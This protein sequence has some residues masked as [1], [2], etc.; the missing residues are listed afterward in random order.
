[1]AYVMPTPK[2]HIEEIRKKKYSIGSEVSNPLTEELHQAVRHLSAELYAKDVHFLMELIQ[3]AEDNEY[4]EGVD[5]SLEFVITSRDITGTG[6]PATLLMFNNER[7]F[8]DKNIESICSVGR[9]TK[10][11]NRKRG[12]IGEKGIG[13]KSVF[14][15]T[16]QPY[17]FSNGYKIKFHEEPCPHCNLGYVV[18]EWVEENP[19]L[20]DIQKIYGSGSTLPT[21][22]LVLPLKPDK[23]KPVKNQLSSVHPEILLFLPKIK[24]LS[25]REDNED[26]RLNTV[27]GIA[28]TSETDFV[29]RKNIDAESYTLH[30][31]ANGDQFDKEC[32]YYMWKQ[33]FPV[34]QENKVER[35]MEVEEWVITLAFPYGQRL[36]RGT[37][38]PGVYAFLPTEMVTNFPFI[39]Q[40]DFLLASSRETIRFDDK[41]NQG[42]LNCVPS[43]FVNALVSLVKLTED[44]PVSSLP[45]MFRFLPVD[46]SSYQE[47]NDVREGIRAILAEEDIIPSESWMEQKFFHKSRE[48]GRLMPS[49]WT[50]LERAKLQGVSLKNLSHH[51]IN[52]LNSSFD[53]EEYD[54]V[55][56]FLGVGIVNNEWYA[57][58]IQSS[59]LVLGVSEEVYWEL[60]FFVAENW[61]AKFRNT[62]I[63]NIPLIKYVDLDGN[64]ALCSITDSA[65]PCNQ[66]V[67]CMSGRESW[68]IKWNRE[69]RSVANRFFMP[70]STHVAFRLFSKSKKDVT[71]EWLTGKVNVAFLSVYDYAVILVRN[72]NNDRRLMV[73][74]AHFLFHSHLEEYLTSAE[75]DYLCGLMPLVDNYGVVRTKRNG[76]LVPA[77]LSKWAELIGSTTWRQ[78][79]YVEL[80]EDYL[81]PGF[82]AGQSTSGKQFMEFLKSH[83]AASDIPYLSPPNAAIQAVSG[84]LTKENAFLLLDWIQKLRY[85]SIPEKFLR[86]IKDGSWLKITMNGYSSY[87]PPSQSFFLT[88]SLGNILQ[89]GS[90]LVDI[91]LVNES[92][93]GEQINE[94]K[95]ELKTIGVIFE[96]KEAC[97]FI[98]NRLM[99]LVASSHVTKDNAF[100]ILHF[101]KFLR[102]Q[103]LP[104]DS[105]IQSIR[106]GSWLKTSH[107]YRS[108]GR[109]VLH[110]QEWK[111][112]SQIS[113]IPFIDQNY[114]G[115][116]IL[117]FKVELQLLGVKV[118]F[119][120]DYQLVI[121]NLKSPTFLTCLT[122]DALLLVLACLRQSDSACKLVKT[123]GST[124]CL[125]T[126]AGYK[127]PGECFLFDPEWGCLF[128]VFRG[129]FPIIDQNFYGSNIVSLKNQLKQ[130]G[131]LV[132]FEDAVKAF[133][134]HFKRQASSISKDQGLLILSCYRKL[135]GMSRSFPTEFGDCVREVKWL[136]TRFGDYRSPEE[137]ILF[138]PDWESISPITLLPF[139]D[140]RF[141]GMD[142]REYSKE[143]KSMG[144]IVAFEEGAQFVAAG[145]CFPLNPCHITRANVV[146]LLKCIRIL[147]GKNHDFPESFFQKVSQKWL[148]TSSA[149]GYSRPNQCLLFDSLWESY[150]LERTDGPFIDEEFYG[151]EIKSY[152]KELSAIGVTV[153]VQKGCPL[154][155]NHLDFHRDF[156]TIVRIYNFL[157]EVKWAPD[158]EAAQRI[159]I[160]DGRK[161]GQWVSPGEC[162]LHD[163]N[164]LFGSQFKVLDKHYQLKL[165]SFFS[166]AF[167]V[168]SNPSVDDYC[169]LWK[170]WESSGQKLSNAE[171]CAFWGCAL[172]DWS[173]ETEK[174]LAESLKKLPVDSGNDGILLFDK[175]DVFLADD[176]QLKDIFERSSPHSLFVW[177]P[178]PSL[179]GLPRTK[180]LE[181]YRNI[182][183]RTISESVQKEEL[184]L[185]EGVELRQVNQKDFLV[186][187]GLIKLILGFLADP[188]IEMDA[189]KRHE[190]VE[191]L[192]N[193]TVLESAEPISVRYTLSLSSGK[194]V[195]VRASQMI[196]WDREIGKLFTQKIERSDGHKNR[197]EYA[198]HFA[199]IISKRV[200][201]DREDHINAMCELIKLAF[202]MEFNEEAVDFLMKSKN[203]Q[204]FKEDEEFLSAAF[205]PGSE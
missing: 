66:R 125:K 26:P 197:F 25:I 110:D 12:Y 141:Y 98:G 77:N 60:L 176:L 18:P 78:E 163:K 39:I 2:E 4:P 168:K 36:E 117:R 44:A 21:T 171:C 188:A 194:T 136:K 129:G 135:K 86:S 83:A 196:R 19:S 57:R 46:S 29:A 138:G 71:W 103:Y 81:R 65:Q 55:L 68:L 137:C 43:A 186:G 104:P 99:S 11:G 79:D 155:A 48:V 170:D 192:L 97:E 52:I 158:S 45:R 47:L 120:K 131:V 8:S 42:I 119:D 101:I 180:L 100:S 105:F 72:L 146:S 187:K 190:T 41:W 116:E 3:N 165:L 87:R 167:S 200:L 156:G 53:R 172:K 13:F 90:V 56:N 185:G 118:G 93:Y 91:P 58:C 191:Y 177:Y 67:V 112:A 33:K 63:A 157:A 28:I 175:R 111:A 179:P 149:A 164:D 145:L 16:A 10:K 123:L 54:P 142:M 88:S 147:Q 126:T 122:A 95:E 7:G 76:V 27:S 144:I 51:G 34:K 183:V 69:F 148:K 73:A 75:V 162:V 106:E 128:E 133:V 166:S 24:Q 74:Y 132:D 31:S 64:V 102:E 203:M 124:N 154:L 17:I 178:Q 80:G 1:M 121:D 94:Y 114:Y 38:S 61:S 49:F 134:S 153:D 15:I 107:G 50:I 193:L 198:T 151:S 130:L 115:D 181:S 113:G 5:P 160:P 150:R 14:L 9:S 205:P 85:G 152:K 37:T 108:P 22:T 20:S 202:L 23:V 96:Y 201:W 184:S 143:L 174:L 182:G 84:P 30:L 32:C 35:R 40:A 199:E 59:N 70:E 189:A 92:Y 139:I 89:E 140:D 204:I 127:S 109:S 62:E 169:M 173:S 195:D 159:W 161:N 6:A 82:Y